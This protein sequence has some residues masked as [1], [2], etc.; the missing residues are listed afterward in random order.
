MAALAAVERRIP[1]WPMERIQRLQSRRVQSIVRHAYETVPYYRRTMDELGLRPGDF[2]TAADLARLPLL[3][4]VLV[5]QAPDEFAS[6]CYDARSRHTFRSSGSRSRIRKEIYWD[7]ASV[8]RMLPR[9]ER[10]RVV[11]ARLSGKSW[12]RRQLHIQPTTGSAA[13]IVA[14]TDAQTWVSQLVRRHTYSSSEPFEALVATLNAIQPD[15]AISYGSYADQFFRFLADTG[16][17]V[18]LPRVW[19]YGG[20][21]LSPEGKDLIEGTFGCTVHSTYQAIET[22]RIGFEC[23]RRQGFHL[24]I[25]LCSVRILDESGCDVAAGQGGE[26]VV[27]NLHNRA[28]VL[29]NYRLGDWGALAV[30][31]CPCGRSLP[32]LARLEG[33]RTETIVLGDGRVLSALI[34]GS[35]FPRELRTAL[36]TQI[37]HPAPGIVRWRIVPFGGVDR[38]TMRSAILSRGKDVLGESTLVEVEFVADIAPAPSGKFPLVATSEDPL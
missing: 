3:D 34:V 31:P 6:T 25:D 5:R 7:N 15:V 35:L 36:K 2:Q 29:L 13:I 27:S 14:K 21:M 37:V 12:R 28:M 17:T 11:L 19:K 10:D 38:E 22:G 4:D 9:N 16:A 26:I 8:L 24:N 20:D 33:R 23:E 30:E 18:T 1:Y 32:L